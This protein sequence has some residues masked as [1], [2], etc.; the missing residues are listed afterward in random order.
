M[1]AAEEEQAELSAAKVAFDQKTSALTK[2]EA[3]LAEAEKQAAA[4]AAQLKKDLSAA[5]NAQAMLAADRQALDAE[6][7]AHTEKEQALEAKRR[8]MHELLNAT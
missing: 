2:R 8:R 7:T 1:A 3:Q 5:A 4:L 6:I